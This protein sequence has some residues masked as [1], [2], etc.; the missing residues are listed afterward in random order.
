YSQGASGKEKSV[1]IMVLG[2]IPVLLT[3]ILNKGMKPNAAE[4]II[5]AVKPFSLFPG[6]CI[7]FFFV[8]DIPE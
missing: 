2:T 6:I 3:G 4:L 1:N 5:P 7:L 8:T